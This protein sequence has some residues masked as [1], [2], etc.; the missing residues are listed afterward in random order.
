MI[1]HSPARS[2]A[3]SSMRSTLLL[4]LSALASISLLTRGAS[5]EDAYDDAFA[6]AAGLE[7]AGDLDG[8]ARAL[9]LVLP[10][11]P[12]DY[13]LPLQLA[14][15]HLRAGRFEQAERAYR[16][17]LAVSPTAVEARAGLA[18]SLER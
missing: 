5:A 13:A 1:T 3:S 16:R 6:R 17:A 8:A 11:Y 12:Q 4:T 14:W 7:P 10:L 18:A 9:E 2:Q 15:I